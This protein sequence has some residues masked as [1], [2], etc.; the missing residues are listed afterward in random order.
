MN[1]DANPNEEITRMLHSMMPFAGSLAK[2]KLNF[3]SALESK[4]P[5]SPTN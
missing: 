1:E 5:D 4:L 2:L 3:Y